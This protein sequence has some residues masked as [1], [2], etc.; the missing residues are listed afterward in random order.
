M[1]LKISTARSKVVLMVQSSDHVTGLAS[2]TLTITA[3]KDGAAFA[4]IA[5]TVTDLGSGWYKL[6][7]TTAHT[8]T[9][10][11]LALHI[12]GAA[13]D[14]TDVVWQ[15]VTDLPGIAQTGDNYARI[16]AAGAGLT[17]LGDTRIAHLDADVSSRSTFAGGAV[18][19]VTG[20]VGSVTADVGITQAGADKVW[21]TAAR[22]LTTFGTLVADVTTAVWAAGTRTLTTFGTV[23]ADV[24][25][26]ATR[27]LT[28]GTNIA[29][30]KGTGVTGF[31][32][33]TSAAT[34]TA[35]R[36]ELTT[37]LGRIDVAISTRGTGTGTA[38]DAAGVR[39]AVGLASAN[40]D[41]QFAA[42]PA[43]D[44]VAIAAQITTDHGAGSYIRNTEPDNSTIT[45]INTKTTNLPTA[46]ADETLV[47]AATNAIMTRL[48]VPVTSLSG[49][50]AA[51]ASTIGG[52]L[53]ADV[54]KVNG[55]TVT[56][57]GSPATPWGP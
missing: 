25:A 45:A 19:S 15:V 1:Q 49:D 52:V 6:A 21:G 44:A 9:L 10:G 38:L 36:A 26:V 14:P 50:V 11:D 48:G 18:A 12:T 54:K 57:N 22:S 43:A 53:N 32:D 20:A 8:D 33:P 4:S 35:V 41:T 47:I 51:V 16:G 24:W 56:G 3:S 34:A 7:L 55:V 39:S 5:P 27:V 46:P 2:L 37:E 13:A 17:A 29:L 40:L 28:A 42:I 31:N 23:A 30:A